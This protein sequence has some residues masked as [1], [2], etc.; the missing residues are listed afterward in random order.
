M[1]IP[2]LECP[3]CYDPVDH[4]STPWCLPCAS[5]LNTSAPILCPL[6]A[7]PSCSAE[8]SRPWARQTQ[9][10][11]FHARYLSTGP[12]HRTLKSWKKSK[13][14][15]VDRRVLQVDPD[16]TQRLSALRLGAI[17]PIPQS[18]DRI[19]RLG[20]SPPLRIAQ[21]LS[22]II[23]VPIRRLLIATRHSAAGTLK[24]RERIETAHRYRLDDSLDSASL[25][26]AGP[27]LLVDDW[28]TSG[29]TLREAAKEILRHHPGAEIHAFALGCRPR[30][31]PI[32]HENAAFYRAFVHSEGH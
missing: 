28:M 5:P 31:E 18:F 15:I 17:I 2:G 19:R 14:R 16:L 4:R 6:C 29:R 13:G 11:S 32:R 25:Q 3:T 30:R 12:L 7:S 24:L 26:H 27:L 9:I 10:R 1:R 21:W 23:G 22:P 20:S 8:C